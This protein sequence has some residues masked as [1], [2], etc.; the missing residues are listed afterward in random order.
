MLF[1]KGH[2][3]HLLSRQKSNK[4]DWR[5]G[6]LFVFAFYLLLMVIALSFWALFGCEPFSRA[7]H[8]FGRPLTRI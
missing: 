6:A 5:M 4:E 1:E 7:V 3:Q 8:A 2:Q